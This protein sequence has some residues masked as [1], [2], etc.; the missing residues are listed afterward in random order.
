MN[1][2]GHR[3]ERLRAGWRSVAKLFVV[4]IVLDGVYQFIALRWFYP[5]EAIVVAVILAIVPYLL[6]GVW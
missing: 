6:C 2:P 1:D 5:G 4:A 3:L